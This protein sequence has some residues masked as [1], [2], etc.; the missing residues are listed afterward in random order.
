MMGLYYVA[1]E[2]DVV[3]YD[4][5]IETHQAYLDRV[6]ALEECYWEF[7]GTYPEDM[8]T[9]EYVNHFIRRLNDGWL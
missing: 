7:V 1:D 9:I 5:C 6:A 2:N 4:G 3:T 8:Y